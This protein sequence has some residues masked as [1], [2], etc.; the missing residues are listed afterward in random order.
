M[1]WHKPVIE[2][3]FSIDEIKFKDDKRHVI[4]K[5]MSQRALRGTAHR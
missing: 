2:T 5:S 4:K 1:Q 3:I